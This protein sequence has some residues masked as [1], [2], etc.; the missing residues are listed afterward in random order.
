MSGFSLLVVPSKTSPEVDL[1][2]A[3]TAAAGEEFRQ[4]ARELSALRSAALL[5]SLPALTAY[6]D[7]VTALESRL[8]AGDLHA[9]FKW[10]DAFDR[11]SLFAARRSVSES[12]NILI[13][14]NYICT[15]IIYLSLKALAFC[16]LDWTSTK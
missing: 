3:V 11:G 2:R 6:L 16:W 14:S 7:Q 15:K 1:E 5:G 8:P 12:R 13:L 4:D 10:R 9:P